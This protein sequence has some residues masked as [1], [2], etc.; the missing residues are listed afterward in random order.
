MGD[1]SRARV[2]IAVI[3]CRGQLLLQLRDFGQ[4]LADPGQWGFF[5][6]H[7][8]PSETPADGL[9]R[10]L[11]EELGWTPDVLQPLGTF[12]AEGMQLIGFRG[13]RDAGIADLVLREGQELG[14][15]APGDLA[16]G[17]AFSQRWNQ[18]F[19]LTPITVRGLELWAGLR[20]PAATSSSTE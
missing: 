9:R 1:R 15:F 14:L 10:E 6:G 18:A 20:F 16:N 19:P 17:L 13:H 12:D 3:W 2:A 11:E 5:G 4:H 8:E 7:L